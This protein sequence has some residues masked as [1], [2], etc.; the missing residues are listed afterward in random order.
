M[1]FLI[2]FSLLTANAHAKCGVEDTRE[3]VWARWINEK[4]LP[5]GVEIVDKVWIR[6][7]TSTV[8]ITYN[9][10]KN[11]ESRTGYRTLLG[12]VPTAKDELPHAKLVDGER[13][14]FH[15]IETKPEGWVKQD[16]TATLIQP[17]VPELTPKY[18]DRLLTGKLKFLEIK[19]LIPIYFG[20]KRSAIEFIFEFTKNSNFKTITPCL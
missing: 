9:P 6:N 5:S 19:V 11:A 14:E 18:K 1:Y 8:L 7:P 17:A 2:S 4:S 15:F 10:E 16:Y 20:K 12:D 13:Y 3:F